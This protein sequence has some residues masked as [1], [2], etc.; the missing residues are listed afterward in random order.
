MIG[1]LKGIISEIH[2][3]E[4]LI[5]T[6]GG[7]FY[8][9]YITPHMLGNYKLTDP[10]EVY[11]YHSIKEDEQKLFA[12]DSYEAF[13]LFAMLISVDGVG[14]KTGFTILCTAEPSAIRKA[15]MESDVLFFQKIKGIGKKTAQRILV[16]LSSSLGTEFDLNASQDSEIDNE[17]LAALESLGFKKADAQEVLSHI[18]TT[19]SLEETIKAA[20]QYLGRHS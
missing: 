15:I 2:G 4:A 8:W 16:D 7:V 19:L 12:F 3:S 6:S 14:P 9:T 13:R 1:K 5:E 18:D 20:L 11:T 17:A 10:V